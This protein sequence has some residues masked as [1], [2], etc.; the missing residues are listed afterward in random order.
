MAKREKEI[1]LNFENNK[2]SYSLKKTSLFTYAF[3]SISFARHSWLSKRILIKLLLTLENNLTE[4][5]SR[6]ILLNILIQFRS[7]YV[8]S[9]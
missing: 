7:D 6:D 9:K 2:I 1:L 8:R 3:K 4:K 5:V